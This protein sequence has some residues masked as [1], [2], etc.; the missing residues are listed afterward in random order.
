ML[1]QLSYL[2]G[3]RPS[4]RRSGDKASAPGRGVNLPI[5]TG[6]GCVGLRVST[7][8]ARVGAAQPPLRSAVSAPGHIPVLLRQVVELLAPA[9]GAVYVDCTAGLGGHA[10][11]IAGRIGPK[12][13]VVLGDLDPANLERAAAAVRAVPGAPRV[14][15]VRGNFAALPRAVA[16]LGLRANMVLA[17]LGFASTQVDDATRG[18]SFLRDGPLDMRLDPSGATTAATLV[19]TLSESDLERVIREYGEDRHARAIARRIVRERGIEPIT[20]TARL[21][22]VVRAACRAAGS[23]EFHIDQATRTFQALRIAV[24]D[25]LGALQGLLDA[26]SDC[27][28]GYPGSPAWLAAGARVG[29]IAFHSLEDRPVKACFGELVKSGSAVHISGGVVTAGTDEQRANPRSRSAKLRVVEVGG[30]R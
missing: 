25:E 17:D 15:A 16:E 26:V 12:G 27:A 21:A 6:C 13:V 3:N 24:N 20:T 23:K 18:L 11:E 22:E 10:V 8:A 2:P 30:W 14:H 19:A 1:Y 28:R 7:C 5:H 9:S 4:L 29:V